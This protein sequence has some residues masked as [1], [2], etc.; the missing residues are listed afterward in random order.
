MTRPIGIPAAQLG[1]R[2][3]A[4]DTAARHAGGQ[5]EECRPLMIG[6]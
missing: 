4:A 3:R 6:A 2:R 1:V 5:P